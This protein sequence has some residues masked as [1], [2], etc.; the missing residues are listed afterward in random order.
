MSRDCYSNINCITQHDG[1]SS[2]NEQDNLYSVTSANVNY[3]P[4]KNYKLNVLSEENKNKNFSSNKHTIYYNSNNSSREETHKPDFNS[5]RIKELTSKNIIKY[6]KSKYISSLDFR[7][8]TNNYK[9]N[10]EFFKIFLK[11]AT[12][13]NETFSL[14][15]T[16][17]VYYFVIWCYKYIIFYDRQLSHEVLES[18]RYS[19]DFFFSLF[20]SEY[21]ACQSTSFID[22]ITKD[23]QWIINYT[24]YNISDPF[25][26]NLLCFMTKR[27]INF[28][29]FFYKKVFKTINAALLNF[30]YDNNNSIG[31]LKHVYNNIINYTVM[32]FN[33]ISG[34]KARSTFIS[35][36]NVIYEIKEFILFLLDMPLIYSQKAYKTTFIE[37]SGDALTF[38]TLLEM[39]F[40]ILFDF[41]NNIFQDIFYLNFLQ[42]QASLAKIKNKNII[43]NNNNTSYYLFENPRRG[44]SKSQQAA[45]LDILEEEKKSEALEEPQGIRLKNKTFSDLNVIANESINNNNNNNYSKLNNDPVTELNNQQL[46][47]KNSLDDNINI[48]KT[49][50]S[51][52]NGH[53][54]FFYLDLIYVFANQEK[55]DELYKKL[56]EKIDQANKLDKETD[57]REKVKFVYPSLTQYFLSKFVVIYSLTKKE[58]LHYCNSANLPGAKMNHL[59]KDY[60]NENQE[61][62]NRKLAYLERFINVLISDMKLIIEKYEIMLNLITINNDRTKFSKNPKNQ[63]NAPIKA[64][65]NDFYSKIIF[66]I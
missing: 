7:Y 34:S 56:K 46:I 23:F 18:K 49:G 38:K 66:L 33:I 30:K 17:V 12:Y 65:D 50:N 58:K 36:I 39:I 32:I 2:Q 8:I 21:L 5:N 11:I 22:A 44:S 53:S 54:I 6:L 16:E 26:F 43:I 42:N 9:I 40:D 31:N 59:N 14:D 57:N 20:I 25:Y 29:N 64:L 48:K 24:I 62:L 63:G 35:K 4:N 55:N 15:W 27:K 10:F 52:I 51:N 13:I 61:I 41:E 37:G 3:F 47:R 60:I 45:S 19:C 28:Q 1:E